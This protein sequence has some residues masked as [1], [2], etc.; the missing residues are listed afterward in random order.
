MSWHWVFANPYLFWLMIAIPLMIVG[1][2]FFVTKR[3]P[4]F[5]LSSFTGF[6]GYIPTLRQ[7]LR[8]LPL[9][10]PACLPLRLL[11]LLLQ[12]HGQPRGDKM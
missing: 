10:L 8:I 4:D 1:Y 11:S 6:R 3:Q 2:L 5:K 9:I 12:D 7:R